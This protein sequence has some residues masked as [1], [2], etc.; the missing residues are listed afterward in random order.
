MGD[1]LAASFAL[2]K[3]YGDGDALQT[4]RITRPESGSVAVSVN[5]AVVPTGWTLQPGGTIV[6][7]TA[8]ATGAEVRAGFR[9]DVPV[10]FAEDRLEI[11]GA[12]FA[13]GE[14]PSVPVIEVRE[15]S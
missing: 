1:G 6:F 9:F 4:R 8:P 2:V 14:A 12:A 15:A 7:T 10:R 3:H 13:A 11:A 5:G